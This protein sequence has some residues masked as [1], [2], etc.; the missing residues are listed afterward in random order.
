MSLL[1][2]AA[3]AIWHDIAPE[4]REEFYAWHGEQ[5]MPERLGI[6]GF[7]RG[8][9]YIAVKAGAEFFNL[10]E[11]QDMGVTTGPEYLARLNNPTPWTLAAVK[12]F[13]NVAR[14]L[15]AVAASSGHS[16]GGLIAT[17]RYDVPDARADEHRKVVAENLVPSLARRRQVA[18][19]HLLVADAD[20]SAVKTTEQRARGGEQNRVPR[21][22]LMLEGWGD[23]AAFEAL[24]REALSNRVLAELGAEPAD[25]GLYQLQTTR[26]KTAAG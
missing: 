10:Y 16:Q 19:A 21:W 8:R 9:R 23:A 7:L 11:Q 2:Q 26:G 1:G 15:C 3:V 18:G 12:H 14:S 5:H 17:W 4:G 6:P 24:C 20:A 25:F 13:R 22:V